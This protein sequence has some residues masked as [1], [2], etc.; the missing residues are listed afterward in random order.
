MPN[1]DLSMRKALC[2]VEGD[3]QK[4]DWYREDRQLWDSEISAID[5]LSFT[6]GGI[7]D[8]QTWLTEQGHTVHTI[9]AAPILQA[10]MRVFSE[11]LEQ[12]AQALFENGL[13]WHE[14]WR[15]NL[16][17]FN[18]SQGL[19]FDLARL[20]VFINKLE[21]HAYQ[22]CLVFGRGGFVSLCRQACQQRGIDFLAA[23]QSTEKI[24][25]PRAIVRMLY[26]WMANLLSETV[27]LLMVPSLQVDNTNPSTLLY[28]QYPQNWNAVGENYTY[29][30]LGGLTANADGD[31]PVRQYLISLL[32]GDQTRLKSVPQLL[33]DIKV[34]QNTDFEIGHDVVERFGQMKSIL[35]SYFGIVSNLKWWLRFNRSLKSEPL[36]WRGVKLNTYLQSMSLRTVLLDWPKNRYL[37]T[38]IAN[39]IKLKGGKTLLLPIFELIEGR[40][41]VRAAKQARLKVVGIQHGAIGLAHRWRVVLPQGLMQRF[42]GQD[43]QPDVIAVEGHV[44]RNWLLEAGLEAG[45]IAAVGAPRVTRDVPQA[46]L[47]NMQK[48][49]LVL[50][51]YHQP[52][53]LFDW[54]I[55][56]LLDID[57]QIVLRPHPT[58]YGKAERWLEQQENSLKEQVCMSL[59]GQSLA[60]NLAR[61]TPVCTL[62]SVTG[63]MVEV[64][65]RGWPLGVILSNWLP[66]Y[67][68]LTATP[69]TGIFSSNDADEVRSWLA[70]LWEDM[71]YRVQYSRTCQDIAGTHIVRTGKDAALALAD[72]L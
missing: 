3:I 6:D 63:A 19:W 8:M 64:A 66:D 23:P 67:A 15:S 51:E 62:A 61:L 50:G 58:H 17:E 57:Y 28:A 72:I 24:F 10:E 42:M 69:E 46:D 55:R 70:R 65:S 36:D 35:A 33:Q 16:T 26:L 68:P 38:C 2:V 44:A 48:L 34:I 12:W 47:D 22:T 11:E 7:A 13:E 39:A 29:R 30:F 56:H 31:Q 32:R 37:E 45:K 27:A 21:Q 40:S 60:E 18:F 1:Q 49:I 59:P 71:G 43:Y 52:H 14:L 4:P 54:C 41:V 9:Y 25:G 5:I 53:V 20:N